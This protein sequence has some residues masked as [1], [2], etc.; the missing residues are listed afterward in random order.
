[1]RSLG[2]PRFEAHPGIRKKQWD[3]VRS[4]EETAGAE[5]CPYEQP[6]RQFSK[7]RVCNLPE[8]AQCH[9][10]NTR[11]ALRG[12]MGCCQRELARLTLSAL[13]QSPCRL[14]TIR[15]GR[16]VP[17]SNVGMLGR[18]MISARSTAD[19]TTTTWASISISVGSPRRAARQSRKSFA[20]ASFTLAGPPEAFARIPR[21]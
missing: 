4:H 8:L 19:I 12:R 7:Q 16:R 20:R 18:Q 11:P 6:H 9:L 2:G 21:M 17:L 15:R 10:R 5:D 1:M 13:S 14:R 3:V